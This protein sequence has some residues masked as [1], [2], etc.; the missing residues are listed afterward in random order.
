MNSDAYADFTAAAL[1]RTAAALK[2]LGITCAGPREEPAAS[3]ET[4]DSRRFTIGFIGSVNRGVSTIINV[5]LEQE[6][7]PT[8]V[9]PGSAGTAWTS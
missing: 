5:L 8:D 2:A 9:I 4:S 6:V 3:R 1:A 7:L